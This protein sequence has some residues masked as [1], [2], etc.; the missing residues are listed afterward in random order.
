MLDETVYY[1][2]SI[3]PNESFIDVITHVLIT[4]ATIKGFMIAA[5]AVLTY[6]LLEIF[7]SKNIEIKSRVAMNDEESGIFITSIIL[8]LVTII[9]A[10]I[11]IHRLLLDR[12]MDIQGAIL[13]FTVAVASCYIVSSMLKR[14]LKKDDPAHKNMFL[15]MPAISTIASIVVKYLALWIQGLVVGSINLIIRI[16][17]IPFV[18]HYFL[19]ATV[20]NLCISFLLTNFMGSSQIAGEVNIIG[21]MIGGLAH[22]IASRKRITELKDMYTKSLDNGEVP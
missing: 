4:I 19:I 5:I 14:H 16:T 10:Y 9:P 18:F 7:L 12:M 8:L 11:G 15:I 13:M 6:F 20:I 17:H 1:D 22:G 21:S 3:G 2:Y